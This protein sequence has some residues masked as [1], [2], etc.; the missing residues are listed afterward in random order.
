M[1]P[2][3][4]IEPGLTNDQSS[5]QKMAAPAIGIDLGTTHSL[6]AISF[7][8][9][10]EYIRDEQGRILQPSVATFNL[11]EQTWC[12]SHE[13]MACSKKQPNVPLLRSIKRYF[14][15][16]AAELPTIRGLHL[17]PLAKGEC[18]S[19]QTMFDIEGHQR[20]AIELSADYLRHLRYLASRQ[21]GLDVQKAVITVPAYFDDAARQATRL[22]AQMAGL[23]VLR[24]LSEPTAAALAYGLDE[25]NE[26]LY[27]VYDLGGGTFDISL[28]R[29]SKGIFHVLATSG[30]T[31]LGGDDMDRLMVED[32]CNEYQML[33]ERQLHLWLL[34]AKRVKEGL[35]IQ[36]EV[37]YVLDVLNGSIKGQYTRTK[38][39]F[40]IDPLIGRTLN[41]VDNVLDDAALAVE[42]L[43]AI[44]LVGGAT[45]VPAI[46]QA[47][48]RHTG[49]PLL[50]H[51]DPDLVVAYGAALQAENLSHRPFNILLDVIP[52]SIGVEMM[53]GIVEHVVERNSTVPLRMAHQFTTYQDGQT[54]IHF[55]IVQGERELAV[56]C[57]S[58]AHF[59]VSGIPPMKAGVA[60]VETVFQVDS[61]G[62]LTISATEEITKT[63]QIITVKP[64][65]GLSEQEMQHMVYS[66]LEHAKE[67]VQMRLLLETKVSAQQLC[68]QINQA[69]H[70][71]QLPLPSQM[72]REL[73]E[74][75]RQLAAVLDT[76]QRDNILSVMKMLE[77]AIQ[78]LAEWQIAYH[79]D[80]HLKGMSIED[81]MNFDIKS[82]I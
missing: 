23:E 13:A 52:L 78:A 71:S 31:L 16:D 74:A 1:D 66:A 65:Y 47:L 43:N 62:I 12:V 57:R 48:T 38:L 32:W 46:S 54:A 59:T 58:L 67:D 30:D 70:D 51:H 26:G 14:G 11:S 41:L 3:T 37:P 60:R 64:T 79:M 20:S 18:A 75:A 19:G 5:E 73:L 76:N 24:L 7:D 15:K 56:N 55:H 40:L 28:L 27:L 81:V 6:A 80:R 8:Q 82:K 42:A 45:R 61:D 29:L 53:G 10:V 50:N 69:L 39:N 44:I 22:S 63:T 25:G 33:D 34:E 68:D 9:R 36:E 2:I 21:L 77:P 17:A 72:H 4:I 49:L 35:T